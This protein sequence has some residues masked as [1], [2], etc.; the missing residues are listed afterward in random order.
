M[1]RAR[2]LL[3]L[4][5]LGGA[6]TDLG[7]VREF[8]EDSRAV[9]ESEPVISGWK[10]GYDAARI[11][12]AAPGMP[13]DV[14]RT[15]DAEASRAREDAPLASQAAKALGLYFGVLGALADE[16]LPDVSDQAAAISDAVGGLSHGDADARQAASGLLAL[17]GVALD[18]WR[19]VALRDLITRADPDVQ[20]IARYLAATSLAVGRADKLAARVTD[21]Y[22]TTEGARS[23]DAAIRALVLKQSRMDDADYGVRVAQA[24][25]AQ[26]AFAKIGADHAVLAAHADGLSSDEVLNTLARDLPTLL[27]ALKT[28]GLK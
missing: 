10:T 9:T 17:V 26:A 5:S 24:G 8:A 13:R 28:F 14:K 25:A 12:A 21:Q 11:L 18:A 20:V 27:H 7:A 6:C 3:A 23:R 19:Q 2:A 22:W 4:A 1:K 16:K 15:L